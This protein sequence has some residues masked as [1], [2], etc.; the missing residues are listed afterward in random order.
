MAVTYDPGNQTAHSVG[1]PLNST[2]WNSRTTDFNSAFQ[3]GIKDIFPR[4]I[5]RS[6]N[7]GEN[8]TAGDFVRLSGSTLLKV[9]NG[10]LA[11]VT[12][13][14]GCALETVTSGN[15]VKYSVNVVEGQSGLTPGSTY[16]IGSSGAI[17]ITKPSNFAKSIGIAYSVSVFVF[18]Y[19]P[20]DITAQCILG[21]KI[22]ISNA[23]QG[24]P[25]IKE[26]AFE[27]IVY[28]H[29]RDDANAFPN[30]TLNSNTRTWVFIKYTIVETASDIRYVYGGMYI[31][32]NAVSVAFVNF[33]ESITGTPPDLTIGFSA[34]A[35]T[36]TKSATPGTTLWTVVVDEWDASIDSM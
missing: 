14:T 24:T 18:N 13:F 7:A 4:Q 36:F 9:D 17:T 33:D 5:V 10:S 19:S 28:D 6:L 31:H 35:V 32:N 25:T 1:F 34:G 29:R 12:N 8:L 2:E 26:N 20:N 23:I 27:R 21:D 11:G 30:Y 15:P 22:E 16:Y 3:L